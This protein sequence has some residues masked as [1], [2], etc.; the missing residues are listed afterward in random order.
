MLIEALLPLRSAGAGTRE[1][2]NILCHVALLVRKFL[3]APRGIL[4]ATRLVCL[5][6]FLEQT[7]GVDAYNDISPRLGFAYDVFGTG[8][9]ALKF[10]WGRY[11][12]FASNDPP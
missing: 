7:P 2:L 9:T 1:I 10:R 11:L 8:R 4:D 6:R 5:A 12:G 3:R